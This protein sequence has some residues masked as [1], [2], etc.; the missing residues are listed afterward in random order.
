[1]KVAAQGAN[2]SLISPKIME[3]AVTVIQVTKKRMNDSLEGFYSKNGHWLKGPPFP[4]TLGL[5][6]RHPPSKLE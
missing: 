3:E 6:R 5:P 1:M 2:L 4:V